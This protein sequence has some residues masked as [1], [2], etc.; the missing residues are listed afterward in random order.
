[1]KNANGPV[2]RKT[3]PYK[4]FAL[5]HTLVSLPDK[6]ALLLL[7]HLKR[8]HEERQTLPETYGEAP[9]SLSPLMNS[10]IT[11]KKGDYCTMRWYRVAWNPF[12]ATR[13]KTGLP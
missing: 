9:T 7:L 11:M 8:I 12:P 5:G 3:L 13:G 2:G 6:D 1:M 4:Y 10:R